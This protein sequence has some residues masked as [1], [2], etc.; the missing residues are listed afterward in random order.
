MRAQASPDPALRHGAR[1]PRFAALLRLTPV[2]CLALAVGCM[3]GGSDGD[4]EPGQ[5]PA[6]AAAPG[7]SERERVLG[8][9]LATHWRIPIAPQGD[10]PPDWSKAEASLEPETCGSCHPEQYAQWRTSLHA[11]AWSPGLAGQLIE[12]ALAGAADVRECQSCH[13]PLAE[14]IPFTRALERNRDF[15]PALRTRGLVCAGCHVRRHRRYGPPRRPDV[16][17]APEPV[18][19]DGFV[20][21]EEFLD[22]RFCAE[23]H[24]F[25]D[26]A[27]VAGKPLQ[28]T[29]SEWRASP[30]AA[31]GRHCQDCHMP[32]RAHLWR[33]IHDPEMVRSG[34]AADL[35][36]HDLEG[37]IL[38]AS[39]VLQ[40]RDVGHAFPTYVT[41][42]VFLVIEQ[43]GADGTALPSTR[44]EAAIGR[45]VEGEVE[46]FDTRV[47]PGESVR[48]D[49]SLARDS[50]ATSLVGRVHVDPDWHYRG[51]FRQLQDSYESRAA[52]RLIGEAAERIA[53]SEYTL[54]RF[55]RDLP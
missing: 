20:V 23:C 38:Q 2:F 45:E 10:P 4:A 11:E 49:Y 26:D 1:R 28:D 37:A 15:D 46:L 39:L 42:R 3:E 24:Q 36:V 22:S 34:V 54:Y 52:R 7:P 32:D 19:H 25:F 51:V 21:R 13:T 16:A 17:P 8:P 33:G 50:R 47:A 43:H 9:F 12:G 31:A 29:W 6:V 35:V 30:Q 40:N 18:P 44:V 41:P 14:Q 5:P 27:G 55:D 48:L 53:E